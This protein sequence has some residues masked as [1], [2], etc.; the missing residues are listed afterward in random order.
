MY[1]QI[2]SSYVAATTTMD[3]QHRA[4]WKQKK[5]VLL[6][7]NSRAGK[8]NDSHNADIYTQINLSETI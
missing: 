5:M 7:A 1:L 8:C 6:H 2:C 4:V 3:E